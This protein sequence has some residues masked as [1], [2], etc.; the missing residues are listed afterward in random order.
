MGTFSLQVT[1][2]AVYASM[3]VD[4]V[5]RDDI[6]TLGT[7]VN[8]LIDCINRRNEIA[9]PKSLICEDKD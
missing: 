8:Y 7:A 2:G 3:A 4:D 6:Q 9:P 5:Y 1:I